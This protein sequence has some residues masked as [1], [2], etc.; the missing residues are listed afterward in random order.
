MTL[1]RTPFKRK[2]PAAYVK[3]ERI[4]PVHARLTVKVNMPR[5]DGGLDS[6]PKAAPAR[7]E[8]YR[9]LVAAMPCA[10]CGIV[11]YSQAAHGDMGKG[12]HI[13][14]DDRTCYPAC[15]PRPGAIGCHALIGSTG[16]MTRDERR[17]L[18]ADYAAQTRA[19]IRRLG[20]WPKNL[21]HL[22]IQNELELA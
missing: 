9:R 6:I 5:A 10:H 19:E 22:E 1:N 4:A 16:S 15:G 14:S 13:K 2:T 12:A 18:E 11:G 17:A 7:S 20:Q 3:A 8:A 21:P